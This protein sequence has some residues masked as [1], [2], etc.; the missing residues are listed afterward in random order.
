L[1]RRRI[2]LT[3]IGEVTTEMGRIYR[4]ARS[5]VMAWADAGTACRIL[6]MLRQAMEVSSLERRLDELEAAVAASRPNGHDVGHALE[7]RP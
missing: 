7:L 3:T 4:D 1:A 2:K 5:G 6:S